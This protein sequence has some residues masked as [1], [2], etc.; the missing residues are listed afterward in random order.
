M[1]RPWLR[2]LALPLLLVA[3]FACAPSRQVG[4]SSSSPTGGA[5]PA[6]DA[7]WSRVLAAAKQEGKVVVAGARGEDVTKVLTEGFEDR[8]GITVEYLGTGGPE[9]PPRV[10]KERSAGLY[11]WDVFVAGTTTLVHGLKPI[12]AL[13]PIE[14]ALI[15][16]EV[17]D[18][19]NWRDGKLPFFDRDHLGLSF[20]LANRQSIYA[21]S[22]QVRQEDI[23]SWRD[24][25]DPR[26]K[27]R[28]LVGRDP[29]VSGY[30]QAVFQQFYMHP[31][32][33]PE[34]IRELAKQEPKLLR[35][36]VLAARWLAE[37]KYSICI[38]SRTEGD[39]L[40]QEGLPIRV[41]DPRLVKEGS[42]VTSSNG[43]IALVNRTPRPN[44]AR[45][46][47]NWV[48]SREGQTLVS[49]ALGDPSQ[50]VDVPTDHVPPW[51][52]PQPGWIKTHTEEALMV[53]DAL[54]AHL[55][56]VFGQ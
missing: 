30:G 2:A 6:A 11:V 53:K 55:R 56:E 13:D 24:L 21:N 42:H 7:E 26:W 5:D 51:E 40:M 16:P 4:P 22:Q 27:E 49:R 17:K 3:L 14:P 43:N 41:L 32:L 33:G 54:E 38:C 20:I 28:I 52:M 34:F 10:E 45:I 46:Y 35:D 1:L 39:K 19:A 15:L 37:G 9:L 31:D 25:L 36:D 8:Y 23:K 50:R 44:V 48:L 18:P 12:G 47:I 29:R